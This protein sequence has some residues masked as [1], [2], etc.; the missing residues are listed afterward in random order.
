MPPLLLFTVPQFCEILSAQ[1]SNPDLDVSRIV[2]EQY[3]TELSRIRFPTDA[4]HAVT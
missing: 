1:R 4:E 3:E 2:I